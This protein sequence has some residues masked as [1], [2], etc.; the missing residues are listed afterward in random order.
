MFGL[1]T[2]EDK[3]YALFRESAELACLTT[4][5]L[6]GLIC[7]NSV[8]AEEAE[9]MHD[10]EHRADKVTTEIV[11]RLNSTLITPLDRE[12]IYTLAQNLDDIVDLSQG[13]VERMSLYHTK[14]PS[15]GAQEIVRTIVKAV[16]HLKTA[17]CCLNSIHFKR[18]EILAATEEVY[19]LEAIGDTLYRQEVARMFEQEKDAIEIIK[20]KEILEHLENTLDQCEE[21][22]DLLKGVVL[23]Y[24]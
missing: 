16:E 17:F 12:D 15:M 20:W 1:S 4:Q 23:K 11:D 13:A 7:Q 24:D 3:F 22:A 6:E 8:S 21:I 18:S 5:K 19:R 10:L 2:K 9:M 14:K